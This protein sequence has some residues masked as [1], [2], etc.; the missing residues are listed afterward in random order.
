MQI[1]SGTCAAP[2]GG[3]VASLGDVT[4]DADGNGFAKLTGTAATLVVGKNF[5]VDVNAGTTAAPTT[6]VACGDQ[7]PA[8]WR[9]GGHGHF[10]K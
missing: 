7:Y 3:A 5:T 1:H 8:R 6:V 9:H 10:S 2:V 4:V